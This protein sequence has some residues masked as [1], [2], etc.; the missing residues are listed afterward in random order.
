MHLDTKKIIYFDQG[1]ILDYIDDSLADSFKHKLKIPSDIKKINSGICRGISYAFLMHEGNNNGTKYI[2]EINEKLN[3]INKK[4]NIDTLHKRIDHYLKPLNESIFNSLIFEGINHQINYLKSTRLNIMENKVNDFLIVKRGKDESNLS[5]IEK[6]IKNN[7]MEKFFLENEIIID[8][9]EIIINIKDIYENLQK[10]DSS[11][12]YNEIV[13]KEPNLRYKIKKEIPLIDREIRGFLKYCYAFISKKYSTKIT[14]RKIQSGLITNNT[15]AVDHPKN[16]NLLGNE[17]TIR[18]LKYEIDQALNKKNAF[19][20]LLSTIG[21]CTAISVKKNEFENKILYKY[22]DPNN[23]II[24][25][26]DKKKF[27]EDINVIIQDESDSGNTYTTPTGTPLIKIIKLEEN[28]GSKYRLKL[29]EFENVDIQDYIKK[30]LI[31]DKFKIELSNNFKM[32][33]K[34]HDPVNNITKATIYGHYKKWNIFSNENDVKKMIS[35]INEK[36]PII[37]NKK[38]SL[39]ITENGDIHSKKFK[40]SLKRIVKNVLNFH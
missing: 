18:E 38:G 12:K 37:K 32:K 17:R 8:E 29:P 26:Y 35:S 7:P 23:G 22:F 16:N 40:L 34:N 39:Y 13:K 36:L 30:N 4:N 28:E 14:E 15:Y 11:F 27:F 25:N 3:L 20:C 21:H 10:I 2:E 31:N 19:Y 33:L 5:F 24:E 6:I 1:K 9:K